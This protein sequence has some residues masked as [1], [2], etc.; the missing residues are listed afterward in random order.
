MRTAIH[1]NGDL[2]ND[3]RVMHI[4]EMA[5]MLK[6]MM[7]MTTMMSTAMM[8]MMMTRMRLS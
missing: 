7:R 5:E 3:G 1:C 6:M 8:T 2:D 4:I